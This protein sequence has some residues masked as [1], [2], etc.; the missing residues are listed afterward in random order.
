MRA[1]FVRFK[2]GD[3]PQIT[4]RYPAYK[5]PISRIFKEA[6]YLRFMPGKLAGYS[7]DGLVAELHF[8]FLFLKTT[9]I[10]L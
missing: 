4:R 3:N 1:F 7:P 8:N 10:T 6:G 5:P 9:Q 2:K